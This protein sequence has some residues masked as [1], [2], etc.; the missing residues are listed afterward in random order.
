[1]QCLSVEDVFEFSVK[2]PKGNGELQLTFNHGGFWV[3]G[4]LVEVGQTLG[5]IRQ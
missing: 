4:A 1:M 5:S 2:M 3:P